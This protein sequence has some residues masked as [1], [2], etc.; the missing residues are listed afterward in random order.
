MFVKIHAPAEDCAGLDEANLE[1]AEKCISAA[2]TQE[3]LYMRIRIQNDETSNGTLVLVVVEDDFLVLASKRYYFDGRADLL[4]KI[5]QSVSQWAKALFAH[6][7]IG[8]RS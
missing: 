6:S 3:N 1:W 5:V 4:R 2:V 7:S 8:G